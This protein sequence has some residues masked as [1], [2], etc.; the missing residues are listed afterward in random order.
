MLLI[1]FGPKPGN[2]GAPRNRVLAQA[3]TAR[4]TPL[5]SRVLG[6]A[7]VVEV[8]SMLFCCD[9]GKGEWAVHAS[10]CQPCEAGPFGFDSGPPASG[11]EHGTYLY[12]NAVLQ[13][14]GTVPRDFAGFSVYHRS[15]TPLW[16]RSTRRWR[17]SRSEGRRQ[18]ASFLLRYLSVSHESPSSINPCRT[19]LRSLVLLAHWDLV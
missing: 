10:A 8:F 18:L 5:W 3:C 12:S 14:I 2:P 1:R 15:G 9:H 13:K 4:G 6:V 7:L 16:I 19:P 17:P 11:A